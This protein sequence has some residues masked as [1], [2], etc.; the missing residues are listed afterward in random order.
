M[1]IKDYLKHLIQEDTNKKK[2]YDHVY[3]DCNYMLHYLIYKCMNEL[4]LY[5]RIFDYFGYLFNII[6][7]SKSINLIFDGKYDEKLLSNP[8][9]QTLELRSKYKK[10]S[11]NYDKQPIYPGS[12]IVSIFKTYIIDIINKYQQINIS[13]FN[14]FTND[15]SIVGE[16]DFKILHNIYDNDQ[17]NICI[18]SKDTD[19]I[20]ISY[21]LILNKN[22]L[23]DIMSN[24]KPIKFIKVN[25]ITLLDK[26]IF[27]GK[28]HI[29]TF[30]YDYVLIIMLLGNDYLP[31]IS[32]ISYEVVI[33][34]YIKYIS[35]GNT[36]IIKNKKINYDNFLK[37]ITLI[38]IDKKI[39]Y[40]LKNLDLKRFK[41]Y[42]NNL[43]WVLK[44]YKVL[45]NDLNYIQEN[46][47]KIKINSVINIYNFINYYDL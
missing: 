39:K 33:N 34:N 25:K 41:I 5:S 14:I 30:K 38:I 8:K 27:N 13:N 44:Y 6:K 32:N 2:E 7:I 40:K 11:D 24:L 17:N 31:K 21:S 4:E 22:I 16:A 36:Y 37:F 29:N 43:C 23:I 47:D 35:Y 46:T 28:K 26:L 45:N 10:V 19:M 20:L 9:S 42:Y 1:G 15:D 3:I 18:I 12:E